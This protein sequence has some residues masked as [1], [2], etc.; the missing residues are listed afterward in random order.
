MK[1]GALATDNSKTPQTSDSNGTGE[2][3]VSVRVVIE[4]VVRLFAVLDDAVELLVLIDVC[5]LTVLLLDWLVELRVV[6]VPE[7][8]EVSVVE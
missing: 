6:L 5:V 1:R 7:L 3:L 4:V 2:K 8:A